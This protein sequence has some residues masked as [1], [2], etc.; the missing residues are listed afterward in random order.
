MSMQN[1]SEFCDVLR[2]THPNKYSLLID[3]STVDAGIMNI[4]ELSD[5][6]LNIVFKS[7]NKPDNFHTVPGFHYTD[8]EVTI[9]SEDSIRMYNN[10]YDGYISLWLNKI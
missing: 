8:L 5:Q 2:L 6:K 9:F 1:P 10:I 4:G 3:N 7:V